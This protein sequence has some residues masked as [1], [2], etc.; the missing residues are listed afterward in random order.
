MN[1][2]CEIALWIP[3][4]AAADYQSNAELWTFETKTQGK[5]SGPRRG[6]RHRQGL[7]MRLAN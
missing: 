5:K 1:K 4:P 3:D 7:T 2:D 6:A